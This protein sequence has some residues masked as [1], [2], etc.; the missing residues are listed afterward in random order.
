MAGNIDRVL[1]TVEVLLSRL[2]DLYDL[3]S[4]LMAADSTEADYKYYFT[5]LLLDIGDGYVGNNFGQDLRNLHRYLCYAKEAGST[6]V[7]FYYD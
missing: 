3:P 1:A 7:F 6:T 5:Y 4:Q 2:P